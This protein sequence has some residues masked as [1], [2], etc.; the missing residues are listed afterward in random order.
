MISNRKAAIFC[1]QLATLI[2]SGVPIERSLA[3]LGRTAPTGGLRRIARD[4]K[5]GIEG[6]ET[7]V[8]ALGAHT[9]HLPHLM[10]TLTEVGE[11]TGQLDEALH[12]AA[13]Y[14]DNQWNLARTMMSRLLPVFFYFAICGALIVFIR[15]IQHEWSTAW[16][17]TTALNIGFVLACIVVVLVA[18][19]LILPVRAG[20]VRAASC[21]PVVAG[22]MRMSAIS[23]FAFAM[24]ACVRAG[25]DMPRAINLSADAMAN[26]A[27][28]G[29]VRRAVMRLHEGDTITEA[30][31]RTRVF[32]REV[33][34]MIETGELSG[35]L[36]ET[37]GYVAA[38]TRFRATTAASA[39][40]KILTTCIYL[41]M[42]LFVAYTVVSMWVQHY[43]GVFRLLDS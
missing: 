6:G 18:M 40:L 11:R 38:T 39:W 28:A 16:L 24:R 9:A 42:L 32:D 21:L 33:M 12:A 3:T 4:S 35:R 15:F 25:L 41:G 5:R 17:K 26:P 19:K 30:L 8:Q 31:G 27:L 22:I 7:F 29:R 14:Y 36:D 10:L 1:N 43:S 23:R 37:M 34:A 13:A 2:E 20:V